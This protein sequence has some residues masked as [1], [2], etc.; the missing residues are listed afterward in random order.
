MRKAQFKLQA[1][2]TEDGFAFYKAMQYRW[3]SDETADP[4]IDDVSY[5]LNREEAI[6]AANQIDLEL[7]FSAMVDRITIDYDILNE[8]IEFGEQFDLEDLDNYRKF[9]TD[10]ETIY[11]G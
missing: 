2:R 7:G 6:T 5:H 8:G 10:Y 1:E 9:R 3:E 11:E 4:Q